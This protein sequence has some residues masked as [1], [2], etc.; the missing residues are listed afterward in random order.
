MKLWQHY[1]LDSLD[2]TRRGIPQVTSKIYT[3]SNRM[4]A[5]QEWRGKLVFADQ[6]SDATVGNVHQPRPIGA[7]PGGKPLPKPPPR[8]KP[9]QRPKPKGG[10]G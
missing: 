2:M 4:V 10:K 6:A 7:I 3:V 5:R 1:I 9:V 8:P